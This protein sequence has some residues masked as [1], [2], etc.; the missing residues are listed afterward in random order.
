MNKSEVL[1]ILSQNRFHFPQLLVCILKRHIAKCGPRDSWPAAAAGDLVPVVLSTATAMGRYLDIIYTAIST[2]TLPRYF[3]CLTLLRS[4][5]RDTSSVGDA[6]LC[7]QHSERIQQGDQRSRWN[8]II[9][10]A[11]LN[12]TLW[13]LSKT[14]TQKQF[15]HLPSDF[16]FK[17][18]RTLW[19]LCSIPKVRICC[20][21]AD[22]NGRV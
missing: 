4:R 21:L 19:R 12:R 2:Q 18:T 15:K 22:M 13:A 5:G 17:L 3:H 8:K 11:S 20:V 14:S 9:Q 7:P 16:K 6:Q 10:L 1:L